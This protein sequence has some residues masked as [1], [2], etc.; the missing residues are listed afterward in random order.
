MKQRV[1]CERWRWAP[2]GRSALV[3]WSQ[4]PQD[5]LELGQGRSGERRRSDHEATFVWR[6]RPR[7]SDRITATVSETRWP[8]FLNRVQGFCPI[9]RLIVFSVNQA[10]TSTKGQLLLYGP[11]TGDGRGELIGQFGY[12]GYSS[13]LMSLSPISLVP[14]K[15]YIREYTSGSHSMNQLYSLPVTY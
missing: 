5:R 8:M 14:A 4:L 13:L 6:T 1:R 7:A 3:S 15:Y 2:L 10:P 11:A 9:W 12:P